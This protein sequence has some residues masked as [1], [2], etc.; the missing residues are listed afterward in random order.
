[1]RLSAWGTI[2]EILIDHLANRLLIRRYQKLHPACLQEPID[3]PIFILGVP[4]S[5][6]TLLHR[7]MSLDPT[8]RFVAC[9]E[10]LYPAPFPNEPPGDV[11]VRLEAARRNL[12]RTW[13]PF[14]DMAAIH[15][16]APEDPEECF[17]LLMN[18]FRSRAFVLL[19]PVGRYLRWVDR[20]DLTETYL[21]HRQQLQI[22]QCRLR[23]RQWV[24]KAPLHLA[25][26]EPLLGAYPDARFIQLHRDPGK[27]MPSTASL[28]R[29]FWRRFCRRIDSH[30]LGR[31]AL[32]G[33]SATMDHFLAVRDRS[34]GSLFVDV[35]Y[36][37]LRRDPV[38]VVGEVYARLGLQVSPAFEADMRDWLARNPQGKHGAHR[39][40]LADFGLDRAAVDARFGEYCRR[41]GVTPEP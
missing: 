41:F 7:L 3:R 27:T 28:V 8:T 14:P 37:R 38:A 39:Y 34:A 32:E 10:S 2:H 36:E 4:R 25:D 17:Y 19:A 11:S 5:G 16:V 40:S 33:W 12:Q 26:V 1:M 22:L 31:G 9:W 21:Y 6:T 23:G 15:P 20:Q 24:L 13:D 30:A 18:S 35:L 29:A